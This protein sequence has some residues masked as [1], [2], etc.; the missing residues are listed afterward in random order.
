M[1]KLTYLRPRGGYITGRSYENI[2]KKFSEMLTM[3]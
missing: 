1:H 2:L 3:A